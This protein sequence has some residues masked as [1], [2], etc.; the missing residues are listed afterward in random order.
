MKSLN[1]M[2]WSSKSRAV[3]RDLGSFDLENFE[4]RKI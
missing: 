2:V 1:E 3:I 4:D